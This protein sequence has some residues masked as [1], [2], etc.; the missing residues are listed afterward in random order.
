MWQIGGKNFSNFFRQQNGTFWL[1]KS[2]AFFILRWNFGYDFYCQNFG[3]L[4]DFW[5]IIFN[6]NFMKISFFFISHFESFVRFIFHLLFGSILKVIFVICNFFLGIPA[7]IS[8]S[9]K[10]KKKFK[11][12]YKYSLL[13][14]LG[15]NFLNLISKFPIW[16]WPSF[17]SLESLVLTA[18]LRSLW[19]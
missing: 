8:K 4:I 14:K 17:T 13:K 3:F 19:F 10:I 1:T 18:F 9:S 6:S 11:N 5:R 7:C 15:S 2:F 12:K 16:R